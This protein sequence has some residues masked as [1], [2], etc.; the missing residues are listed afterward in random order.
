MSDVL[1]ENNS[2]L[3]SSS[4]REETSP[5]GPN[6]IVKEWFNPIHNNLYDQLAHSVAQTNRYKVL[7][8]CCIRIFWNQTQVGFVHFWG[9]CGCEEHPLIEVVD[10]ARQDVPYLWQ[11]R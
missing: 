8:H 11:K 5:S 7:Q 1:L 9:H 4:I 3:S 10:L 6:D 2:I